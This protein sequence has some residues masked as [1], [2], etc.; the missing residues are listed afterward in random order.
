MEAA[1][2]ALAASLAGPGYG[3]IDEFAPAALVAALRARIA[4]L[5]AA[6]EL[7]PAAVG[8]GAARTLRPEVRGDRLA[9]LD[10][11]E[12]TERE[13]YARLEALRAALNREL[14]LGLFDL[15]CHYAAYAPGTRYVRH[16]DRSVRGAERVLSIVLYLNAEWQP[17]D[18][19]ELL[20]HAAA[21]PVRVAPT[22]GRLVAFLSERLEHEVLEVARER[23]SVVG[24]FR[25]RAHVPR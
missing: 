18:G 23:L 16:L 20:I 1:A 7:R 5:A 6:G 21:G 2:A 9:W 12:D 14:S 13:L 10:G 19:G 8:G 3:T 15:E 25:R 4:A 24:W 22:A 11:V 17:G